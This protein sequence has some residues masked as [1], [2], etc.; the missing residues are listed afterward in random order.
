MKYKLKSGFDLVDFLK[1]VD[2]CSGEVEYEGENGDRLNLKSQ[3]SKYLL[4]T[5]GQ[6]ES[7]MKGSRIRCSDE[8]GAI[9]A[10]FLVIPE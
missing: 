9:L 6:D 10:E 1:S 3:L 7:S 4:L 8:D 5:V 2:R